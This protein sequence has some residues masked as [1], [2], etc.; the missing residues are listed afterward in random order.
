MSVDPRGMPDVVAW[1]DAVRLT[2]SSSW[3]FGRLD[4]P[5]KWQD[6]A[7]AFTTASPFAEQNPPNPYQFSDW[8]EFAMRLYPVLEKVST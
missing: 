4:D 5:D 2:V 8:R 6:W 3:A 7:L 1:S